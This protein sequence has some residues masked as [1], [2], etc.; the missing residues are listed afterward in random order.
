MRK[1]IWPCSFE[2]IR[3]TVIMQSTGKQTFRQTNK[4]GG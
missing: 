2:K 3:E 1:H 4:N